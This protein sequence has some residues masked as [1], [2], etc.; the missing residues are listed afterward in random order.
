MFLWCSRMLSGATD[1][2]GRSKVLWIKKAPR[3]MPEPKVYNFRNAGCI[4]KPGIGWS[5]SSL[6]SL[7]R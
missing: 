4:V 1:A 7:S 3:L 5:N 2:P 6:T